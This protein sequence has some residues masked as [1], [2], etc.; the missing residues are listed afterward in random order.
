MITASQIAAAQDALAASHRASREAREMERWSIRRGTAAQQRQYA[1]AVRDSASE[2]ARASDVL[3][4]LMRE[5]YPE[6]YEQ[7]GGRS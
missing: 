4:S 5:R 3:W 7:I 6:T 2:S 1:Q